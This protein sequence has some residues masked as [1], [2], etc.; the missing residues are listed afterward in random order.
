MR[1]TDTSV[2]ERERVAGVVGCERG[3]VPSRTWWGLRD[4]SQT[5]PGD[6]IGAS[7]NLVASL[8]LH[9]LRILFRP[10]V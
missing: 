3:L 4:T 7:A 9:T 10:R 2:R 8:R 1:V 5:E 6:N